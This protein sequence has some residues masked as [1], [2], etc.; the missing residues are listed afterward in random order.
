M[1]HAFDWEK[2]EHSMQVEPR[3][4]VSLIWDV[5]LPGPFGGLAAGEPS[6]AGAFVVRYVRAAM[7][8]L[9]PL[10]ERSVPL[11]DVPLTLCDAID[12]R[13]MQLWPGTA[14]T[15]ELE[16]VSDAPALLRVRL[17]GWRDKA[18]AERAIVDWGCDPEKVRE[19]GIEVR[20]YGHPEPSAEHV[21]D[22]EAARR[23]RLK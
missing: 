3:T 18:S 12:F 5:E 6:D 8:E 21:L 14:V 13:P 15:A 19:L 9:L 1:S 17:K 23:R 22:R 11:R 2:G 16:N 10:D 4:R 20:P 7:M